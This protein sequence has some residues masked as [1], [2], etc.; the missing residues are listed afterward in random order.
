MIECEKL[1]ELLNGPFGCRMFRDIEMQDSPRTNLHCNEYLDDPERG[2]DGYEEIASNH[3]LSVIP[4]EGRPA[5]AAA[6]AAW[7]I[8]NR[9]TC[10]PFAANLGC[11]A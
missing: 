11:R 3:H 5:L 1:A 8:P 9:D 2:S 4:D 6:P 7:P 10:E